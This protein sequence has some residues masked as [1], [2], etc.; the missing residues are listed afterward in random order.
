MI[1]LKNVSYL[2]MSVRQSKNKILTGII[3]NL[4]N[5]SNVFKLTDLINT[6]LLILNIKLTNLAIFLLS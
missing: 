6:A 2:F 5:L 3:S 4:I 1:L